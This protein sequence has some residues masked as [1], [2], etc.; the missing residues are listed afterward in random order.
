MSSGHSLPLRTRPE[1]PPEHDGPTSASSHDQSHRTQLEPPARLTRRQLQDQQ[2][3]QLRNGYPYLSHGDPDLRQPVNIF[4][5]PDTRTFNIFIVRTTPR[6]NS[7]TRLYKC[8]RCSTKSPSTNFRTSFT[9]Y[10]SPTPR[11]NRSH[12]NSKWLPNYG[13]P[14]TLAPVAQ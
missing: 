6:C 7:R 13:P 1:R 4:I 11:T 14:V 10:S 5:F 12:R 3:S 2:V 9:R 8:S